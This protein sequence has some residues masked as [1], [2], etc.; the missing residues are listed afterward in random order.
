MGSLSGMVREISGGINFQNLDPY[1][2]SE[3]VFGKKKKMIM[4]LPYGNMKQ[5]KSMGFPFYFINTLG[6]SKA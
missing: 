5:E 1:K 2:T 3:F 4:H 6:G